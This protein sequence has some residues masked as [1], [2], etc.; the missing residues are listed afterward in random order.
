MRKTGKVSV[1]L[2]EPLLRALEARAKADDE[3]PAEIH[4]RALQA[5]LFPVRTP[6]RSDD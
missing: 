4:R 5:Y 3:F 1:R 6:K 2:P